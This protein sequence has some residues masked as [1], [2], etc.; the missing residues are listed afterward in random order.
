MSCDIHFFVE[1]Q[2]DTGTWYY[3]APEYMGDDE[4]P[5]GPY[6]SESIPHFQSYALFGFLF[7][8]VRERAYSFSFPGKFEL[9]PDVS[10]A[11][12]EAYEEASD[13]H[14]A[15]YLTVAELR[16]RFTEMLLM[17]Q[18]DEVRHL[19]YHCIL[20]YLPTNPTDDPERQRIV[21]WFDN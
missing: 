12:K 2:D 6:L 4:N 10:T 11:I 17:P 15:S 16:Q 8:G 21:F 19:L 3:Q 5:Y 14:S 18:A 9:P 13:R 1:V 20:K 7:E